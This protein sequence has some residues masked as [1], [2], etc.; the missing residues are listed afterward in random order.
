MKAPGY[1]RPQTVPARRDPA[2]SASMPRGG[3]ISMDKVS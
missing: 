1:G 3:Y 2:P